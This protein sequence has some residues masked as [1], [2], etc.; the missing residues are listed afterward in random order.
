[1]KLIRWNER[2]RQTVSTYLFMLPWIVGF[3]ALVV[4]PFFTTLWQSFHQEMRTQ[5]GVGTA[6][7]WTGLGN[8]SYAFSSDFVLRTDIFPNYLRFILFRF[9]LIQVFALFCALL[10]NRH[11]VG[12]GFFR[13]IFFVPVLIFS[14]SVYK[15]LLDNGGFAYPLYQMQLP[16]IVER[17]IFRQGDFAQVFGVVAGTMVDI[18]ITSGVQILVFLAALQGIP[19]SLYEAA[20]VD[21]CTEWESFWKITLPMISPFILLNVI[22]TLIESLTAPWNTL[23]QYIIDLVVT[24]RFNDSLDMGYAS[25]VAFLFFGIVLVLVLAALGLGRR[26]VFYSGERK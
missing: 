13:A 26:L 15:V 17:L 25:A 23:P 12:R 1:M 4:V 16:E 22:F 10:L 8:W 19:G 18:M 11:F 24:G 2:T 5:D 3:I 6:W 7:A 21:G 9:P 14:S 20:Y